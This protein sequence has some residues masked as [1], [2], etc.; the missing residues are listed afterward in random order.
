MTTYAALETLQR[1]V[2]ED[3]AKVV[4]ESLQ[5]SDW[6]RVALSG[7]ST[8]R[9]IYELLADQDL[10]WDRIHWYWGD[11]RN[12]PPE[13]A[14]SNLR[15][16]REALL[17]R[18]SIPP[19]NIHPVPVDVDR[20]DAAA[21]EYERRLR[22][23]FGN[24]PYPGWDLVLLGLGEDAHTASLFPATAAV[25]ETDRWFVENW[26]EK[27]ASYRY[28]LTAPAINSGREIWFLVAG[29]AKRQALMRVLDGGR[30]PEDYPA[31]LI[32]PTRWLVT[33]DVIEDSP[34]VP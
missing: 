1:A 13:H 9:R 5:H 2:A 28:T 12:V 31:Q 25:G 4:S 29:Q 34:S 23:A 3:F 26:V 6:F 30:R 21:A 33:E 15:M 24:D 17:D 10:P 16:V 18:A 11:E 32:Q 27:L 20:P 19:A 7:G 14:D 22:R 8:P